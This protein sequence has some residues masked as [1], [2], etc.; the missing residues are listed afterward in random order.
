MGSGR[1]EQHTR[2]GRRKEDLW[3]QASESDSPSR[4][5]QERPARFHPGLLRKALPGESWEIL[6]MTVRTSQGGAGE[7]VQGRTTTL[8]LQV[9]SVRGHP[10]LP[11]LAPT[12][13]F[14]RARERTDKEQEQGVLW[15]T[16]KL[17]R[18]HPLEPQTQALS[19]PELLLWL[20]SS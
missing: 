8:L 6:I 10:L 19:Q 1:S 9:P 3:L 7:E 17:P 5:T 13:L 12:H 2:E 11:A 20:P 16:C 15:P 4:G 18:A 14:P